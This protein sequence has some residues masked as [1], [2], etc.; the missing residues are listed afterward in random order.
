M[1]SPLTKQGNRRVTFWDLLII[2]LDL[3]IFNLNMHTVHFVNRL[4]NFGDMSS[5]SQDL[6]CT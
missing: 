1:H 5:Q 3:L 4:P 6:E 2:K